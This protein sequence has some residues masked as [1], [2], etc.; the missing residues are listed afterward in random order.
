VRRTTQ[1]LNVK[2]PAGVDTGSRLKL[3]GEGAGGANGGPA[4]DLYVIIS[5]AEH[6][7]FK[8]HENSIVCEVPV[9]FTQAALGAEIDVP[10]LEGKVKMKIPAGTQSGAVF[11]LRGKGVPD[12]RGYGRGDQLV[13]VT[14]ET[15]RDLSPK[16]RELLEEFARQSGEE[17]NPISKGFF[18]KVREMFG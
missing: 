12:T 1:R 14:V 13:Q 6:A 9:S 18:D 16:Q 4:G 10:T 3:R 15:P 7:L 11:R 5:V 17:V 2:I 8:R